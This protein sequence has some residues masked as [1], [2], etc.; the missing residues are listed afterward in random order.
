MIH[1]AHDELT[2]L[3]RSF[4]ACFPKHETLSDLTA[5]QLADLVISDGNLLKCSRMFLG[6]RC[7]RT[8]VQMKPE[9]IKS[10][11]SKVRNAYKNAGI[12]LQG[13][14]PLKNKLLKL[15]SAINPKAQGHSVTCSYL[16]DLPKEMKITLSPSEKDQHNLQ[17]SNIQL[18]KS[19]PPVEGRIDK[20]WAVT[21]KKYPALRHVIAPALSIF[22]GPRIEQSFTIMNSVI[23]KTTNR[24]NIDTFNAIQTVKFDLLATNESS[25]QRYHREDKFTSPVHQS[26]AQRMKDTGESKQ[27]L[28]ALVHPPANTSLH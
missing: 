22:T 19:L 10:F 7:E 9:D 16:Q 25:I 4:L 8:L 1:K 17:A 28:P 18:D 11:L 24:L 5:R 2:E 6:T 23:N 26:V 21:L 27:N 13:K 20:W 15:L 14:L 12:Y 3:F